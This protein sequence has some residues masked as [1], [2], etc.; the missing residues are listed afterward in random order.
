M[1]PKIENS[2]RTTEPETSQDLFSL[3]VFLVAAGVLALAFSGLTWLSRGELVIGGG[4]SQTLDLQAD[5]PDSEVPQ[6]RLSQGDQILRPT[7]TMPLK[8]DGAE[9]IADSDYESAITAFERARSVDK[10]DPEVLIYLNNARIAEQD[11]Y[12][13]GVVAPVE[14]DPVAATQILRGV[15]Q[16]QDEINQ[17]GGIQGKPL[18]ILLAD[19]QGDVAQAQ[20][21]A[22]ELSQSTDVVG[23]LG[24]HSAETAEA[25]AEIYKGAALPVISTSPDG[26]ITGKTLLAN[27]LPIE[28]ALAF[29]MDKLKHKT[30]ILFYDG[31]S[32]YSQAFRSNFKPALEGVKGTMTAEINLADIPEDLATNPPEAEIFLLSPGYSLL[33]TATD[34]IEIIPN[35]KVDHVYRHVFGGHELFQPEVLKMFGSMA[36]GTILAVPDSVYQ[37]PASPFK[38]SARNLWDTAIDWKTSA[39]YDKIKL[40]S[41]ALEQDP[42]GQTVQQVLDNDVNETV[43]LLRV[44]IA[45]ETSTGYEMLSVGTMTKDGEFKPN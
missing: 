40:I 15:A 6:S 24:H 38:D 30:V 10:T 14:A 42:T 33:K 16:A 26:N 19:D 23:V 5:L 27:D 39:S 41:T 2:V 7:S 18:R 4:Q 45:P 37:S 28:K 43:R 1:A 9:A 13:I 17:A 44:R 20:G 31:N 22:T 35:E 29:Y 25:T 8:E 11:A 21:I 12:G 34:S 36:T 32:A 3:K